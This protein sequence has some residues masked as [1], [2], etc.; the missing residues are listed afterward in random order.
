MLK[1]DLQF[2]LKVLF[3]LK[4]FIFLSS[5]FGYVDKQLDKKAKVNFKTYRVTD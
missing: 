2:I 1:K 4:M 5:L 3:V